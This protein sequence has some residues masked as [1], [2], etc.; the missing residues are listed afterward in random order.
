[1]TQSLPAAGP[2]C[3][4]G[5]P[6]ISITCNIDVQ[7]EHRGL[8]SHTASSFRAFT[9]MKASDYVCRRYLLIIVANMEGTAETSNLMVLKSNHVPKEPVVF[10][11]NGFLSSTKEISMFRKEVKK[12]KRKPLCF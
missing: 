2:E 5:P 1:M 7:E 10:R 8:S 6:Y 12:T 11:R 3:S 9:F 4:V